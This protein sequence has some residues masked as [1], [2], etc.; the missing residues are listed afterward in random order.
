MVRP[1]T[2]QQLATP[3][4]ASALARLVGGVDSFY[5]EGPESAKDVVELLKSEITKDP[6]LA[7]IK[8]RIQPGILGGYYPSSDT[9]TLGVSNPAVAAHELGHAK[10][11]R[12][13]KIYGKILQAANSVARTNN[14]VAL[15]AMLALR[16]FVGD[17]DTRNEIFNILSGASAAIIAPGLIEEMSASFDAVKNAPDKLKALKSLVPAFLHHAASASIPVGIYQLGRHL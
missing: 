7:D 8:A 3:E 16:A 1:A 13:S 10:N 4:G 15:P 12:N 14:V 17:E 2:L 5:Q 11:I 9:I 6:R